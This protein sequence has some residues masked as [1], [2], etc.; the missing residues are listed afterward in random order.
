MSPRIVD[1][2]VGAMP[3]GQ[4][5][6]YFSSVEVDNEETVIGVACD[7]SDGVARRDVKPVRMSRARKREMPNQAV[8]LRI[9]DGQLVTGLNG[10][11][12]SY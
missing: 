4:R 2:H 9:D 10:R 5:A 12:G 11:V 6:H 7:I 3:E 8:R 1:Q